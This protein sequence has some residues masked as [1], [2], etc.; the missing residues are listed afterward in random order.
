MRNWLIY[1]LP[2]FFQV[3]CNADS[4]AQKPDS[5]DMAWLK[6]VSAKYSPDTW[7]MLMRYDKFPQNMEAEEK[8]GGKISSYKTSGTFKYVKG[9]TRSKLLEMMSINVHEIGHACFR[10]G[11]FDYALKKGFRLDFNR[12]ELILYLNQQHSFFV[13]WPRNYFFP[14]K[15]LIKEI[16]DSLLTYRYNT[17]IEGNSATQADGLFGLLE[18]LFAYYLDSKYTFDILKAFMEAEGEE[19]GFFCWVQNSQSSMVAYYEFSFFIKEYLL[20]MK[21]TY[22]NDYNIFKD[23]I[24][25]TE[26][27]KAVDKAYLSLISAYE[28]DVSTWITRLNTKGMKV[29]KNQAGKLWMSEPNGGFSMG[30]NIFHTDRNILLPVLTG[31]RYKSL[32]RDFF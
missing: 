12:V 5:L 26:A 14:S 19:K 11:I 13:S 8:R 29:F 16:P 3:F 6:D 1:S 31:D 21:K 7:E 25:F 15:E 28:K 2:F 18:E 32:K 4:F 20:Y 24:G 9:K 27:W 22:P 10:Y 17:Y 30:T 23:Y